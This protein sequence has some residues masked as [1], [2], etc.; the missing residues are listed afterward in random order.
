M[1][2]AQFIGGMLT[3]LGVGG[4]FGWAAWSAVDE[5]AQE[6]EVSWLRALAIVLFAKL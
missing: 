3:V 6:L 5:L 1:I 4:L 2:D